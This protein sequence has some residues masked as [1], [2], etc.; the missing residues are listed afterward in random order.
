[1]ATSHTK[2]CFLRCV[3]LLPGS[4]TQQRCICTRNAHVDSCCSLSNRERADPK[5]H[6]FTMLG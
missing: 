3:K 6:P 4:V 2:Q 5:V 1:M